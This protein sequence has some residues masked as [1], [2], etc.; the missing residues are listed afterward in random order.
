MM[1]NVHFRE[2]YVQR[3]NTLLSV[4]GAFSKE[5]TV[6]VYDS[7]FHEISM[8]L[9]C[10]AARW[11][12]YRNKVHPYIEQGEIYTVD[13]QYMK[14]RNRLLSEYFPNRSSSML[15]CIN[16]QFGTTTMI[17]NVQQKTNTIIDVYN[18]TGQKMRIKPESSRHRGIYIKDGRKFVSK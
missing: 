13:N 14:E 1:K 7:I 16:D 4:G 12:D 10:E 15:L 3:A 11:G 6:A 8:A 5:N 17:T 9:Y 18:L 2:E